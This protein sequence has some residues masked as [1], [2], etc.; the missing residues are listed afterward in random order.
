LSKTTASECLFCIFKRTLETVLSL[1]LGGSNR[2]WQS[3]QVR[4]SEV[5]L[6]ICLSILLIRSYNCSDADFFFT[7]PLFSFYH[8]N[9]SMSQI[10]ISFAQ[11]QTRPL[12]PYIFI[13]IPFQSFKSYKFLVVRD[14]NAIS[15]YKHI[16][17]RTSL[18]RTWRDCQNLFEPPRSRNFR[19]KKIRL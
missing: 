2:F 15:L 13:A 1:C 8:F 7:F 12:I 16:Y 5:L 14:K 3:L 18:A 17:S 11:N 4:A 6:Y 9:L 19:E 10:E